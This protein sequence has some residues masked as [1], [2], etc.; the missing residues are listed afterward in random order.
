MIQVTNGLITIA[1]C[2]GDGNSIACLVRH[3]DPL[4]VAEAWRT[5]RQFSVRGVEDLY[6][7][8]VRDI[9]YP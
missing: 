1:A 6:L 8:L 4:M 7:N 5:Y 9:D 3:E 2:D